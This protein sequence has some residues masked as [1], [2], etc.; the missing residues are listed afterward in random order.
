MVDM[1]FWAVVDS[2]KNIIF[3]GYARTESQTKHVIELCKD[4]KRDAV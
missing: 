3:D 1:F 4:Q 2:G